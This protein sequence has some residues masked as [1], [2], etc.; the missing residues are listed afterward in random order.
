MDDTRFRS[1]PRS[2]M[3]SPT[4]ERLL[5]QADSWCPVKTPEGQ[6]EIRQRHRGLTQRQ[7]TMLLLVDGHRSAAHVKVLALQAG[8]TDTC[9]DE[10][11]ELGLIAATDSGTPVA[12]TPDEHVSEVFVPGR[13]SNGV[14]VSDAAPC[15]SSPPSIDAPRAPSPGNRDSDE[16]RREVD[17]ESAVDSTAEAE[18]LVEWRSEPEPQPQ[19]GSSTRAGPRLVD[20]M[21]G[22]LFPL[23]ESAFGAF[24]PE[25]ATLT[26]DDALEE[27]RRI[28]AREVRNKAPL[29]GSFTLMKLRRARNRQELSAL[30]DEVDSHI[31][32]PMRHLSAH[33]TLLHV[34]GLLVSGSTSEPSTTF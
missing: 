14:A 8:A 9:F 4:H 15:E 31:S 12:A 28:L 17:A 10:L 22:S 20:S 23:I 26:R 1:N 5:Y 32:K 2:N 27:A 34:R 30:F 18:E 3:L 24:G 29:T 21:L 13:A 7:R 33:Q 19:N 11:L 16:C 6:A 25:D